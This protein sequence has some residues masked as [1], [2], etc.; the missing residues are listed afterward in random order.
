MLYGLAAAAL[1]G[2]YFLIR[3]AWKNHKKDGW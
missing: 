3:Q 1:V 2:M